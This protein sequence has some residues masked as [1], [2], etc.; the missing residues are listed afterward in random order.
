MPIARSDGNGFQ[1]A[2]HSIRKDLSNCI[3]P[4]S[5][6][7]QTI[8]TRQGIV[9]DVG[10]Q[11]IGQ[12]NKIV[13]LLQSIRPSSIIVFNP[14]LQI[15]FRFQNLCDFGQYDTE[16]GVFFHL[17]PRRQ[18]R[19]GAQDS[20]SFLGSLGV[21]DRCVRSI[22]VHLCQG[23]VLVHFKDLEIGLFQ[24]V[25]MGLDVLVNRFVT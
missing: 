15:S 18:E 6:L 2:V 24:Q 4:L 7:I 16:L 12:L 20:V 5:Q 11:I 9:L 17:F 22:H 19:N 10:R 3:R 13:T 14:F 21:E 8:Q 25:N 23:E 1:Q